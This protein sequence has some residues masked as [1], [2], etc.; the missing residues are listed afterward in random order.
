MECVRNGLH[1]VRHHLISE[2]D[3]RI[4]LYAQLINTS[5]HNTTTSILKIPRRL[6]QMGDSHVHECPVITAL[7]SVTIN[8]VMVLTAL[9]C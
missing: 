3:W 6:N 7:Q 2:V 5:V 1:N 8:D 4:K 9:Y